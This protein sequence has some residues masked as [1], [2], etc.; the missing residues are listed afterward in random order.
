MP[1]EPMDLF[2]CRTNNEPPDWSRFCRI[3]IR[4][5]RETF[6]DDEKKETWIVNCADSEAEFWT[7]YG[8][9]HPSV[10]GIEIAEA[11]TDCPTRE[12]AEAAARE[13]SALS[14]LPVKPDLPASEGPPIMHDMAEISDGP[15]P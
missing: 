11:I 12:A 4:G 6:A 1:N 7:V 15:S 10:S 5:C 14:G 3:E 9:E 13:I 2:N 8:R